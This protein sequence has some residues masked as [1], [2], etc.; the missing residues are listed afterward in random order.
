MLRRPTAQSLALLEAE[1][2]QSDRQWVEVDLTVRGIARLSWGT[3]HTNG[4]WERAIASRTYEEREFKGE[5][6]VEVGP[7]MAHA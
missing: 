3:I 2:L 5:T 1:R 6:K 7:V 4:M